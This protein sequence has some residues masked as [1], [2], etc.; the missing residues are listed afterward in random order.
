M[1]FGIHVNFFTEPEKNVVTLQTCVI[2]LLDHQDIFS[3]A[4]SLVK[5]LYLGVPGEHAIF[6]LVCI[7]A[8]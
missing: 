5:H 7:S 6:H 8:N 2:F 3:R 1:Y 4:L